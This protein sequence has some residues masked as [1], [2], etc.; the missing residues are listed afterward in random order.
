MP[1]EAELT[2]FRKLLEQFHLKTHIITKDSASFSDVELGIRQ[3]LGMEDDYEKMF[4]A[5]GEKVKPS[6]IYKITDNFLTNYVIF[7]MPEEEVTYLVIGPYTE[8]NITQEDFLYAVEKYHFSPRLIEIFTQYYGNIPVVPE[9]GTLLAALRTLGD[10]LWGDSQNYTFESIH[11]SLL[12]S[13]LGTVPDRSASNIPEQKDVSFKMKILEERYIAENQ[14]IKMISQ[15][16]Y[17]KADSA[18]ASNNMMVLESRTTDALRNFKNYSIVFNTLLR[19]GAEAGSVH[20]LYIDRVSSAYARRIE[21]ISSLEQ[22]QKLMKEM[23]RKYCLLVKNHSMKDYSLLIQKVIT[24]IDADLT[25]DQSLKTHA[26]ILNV[27]PSYLSTLFRKEIG[28]TLTE[29]VNRKRIEH[30]LFLLNTTNLQIQTVAQ[31]CGMPDINYFTRIF[32]KHI[33]KTPKEYKKALYS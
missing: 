12:E 19:K 22:G 27:N 29:Y 2:F 13:Y 8:R 15:G 25:A 7:E 10:I 33:G 24:R 1:Y 9:P 31:Q 32:K 4:D 6:T 26:S 17:N 23:L 11:Y 3:F 16:N 14:L 21:D 5:I 30:G 28:V 20:P 18:L